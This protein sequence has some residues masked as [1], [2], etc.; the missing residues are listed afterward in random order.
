MIIYRLSNVKYFQQV[1]WMPFNSVYFA[2]S[3]LKLGLLS[4]PRGGEEGIPLT[5]VPCHRMW[6]IASKRAM[7]ASRKNNRGMYG[8]GKNSMAMVK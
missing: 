7:A 6:H 2:T 1:I 8:L 3:Q 5:C 4:W